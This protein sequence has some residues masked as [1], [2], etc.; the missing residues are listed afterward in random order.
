[1]LFVIVAVFPLESY[2]FWH[3]VFANLV[4]NIGFVGLAELVTTPH[5][6]FFS[7]FDEMRSRLVETEWDIFGNTLLT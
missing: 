5:T 7:I 3:Q 6:I 4:V 1:M 2:L